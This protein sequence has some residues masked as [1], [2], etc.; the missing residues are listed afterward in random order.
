MTID[1]FK[2]IAKES[3]KHEV[4][5]VDESRGLLMVNVFPTKN[6]ERHKEALQNI[7]ELLLDYQEYRFSENAELDWRDV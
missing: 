6:S 4:A 5:Q 2:I 1:V 3:I 7:Q